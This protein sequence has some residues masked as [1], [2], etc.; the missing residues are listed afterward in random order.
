MLTNNALIT[1]PLQVKKT[2]ERVL[3]VA[4]MAWSLEVE[5]QKYKKLQ[6][7][8]ALTWSIRSLESRA[9]KGWSRAQKLGKKNRRFEASTTNMLQRRKL[10]QCW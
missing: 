8:R 3:R 10:S 4:F 1:L 9:F 5:Y 7:R 6:L 2:N